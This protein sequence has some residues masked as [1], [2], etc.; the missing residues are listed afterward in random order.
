MCRTQ[1]VNEKSRDAER[2]NQILVASSLTNNRIGLLKRECLQFVLED[3]SSHHC[4]MVNVPP[5]LSPVG[6]VLGCVVD[7]ERSQVQ[8][9]IFR[10]P[11]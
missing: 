3:A 2:S 9:N 4:W 6:P 8:P 10:H 11:C 7:F 1:A 5:R